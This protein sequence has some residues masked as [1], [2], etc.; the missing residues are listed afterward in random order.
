MRPSLPPLLAC[1]LGLWAAAAASY[2]LGEG[3]E[4][5]PCLLVAAF[6]GV[7]AAVAAA[8]LWRGRHVLACSAF[9]GVAL[10]LACGG[11]G[12]AA[13]HDAMAQAEEASA[14]V[15]R[16]EALEDG[17]ASAYGAQCR[18]R[19]TAA[20]GR[21][22]VVRVS[23]PEGVEPPRYGDAFEARSRLSRP[24]GTTASYC[25]Q[26]GTAAVARVDDVAPL[27]RDGLVGLLLGV[28]VRAVEALSAAGGDAAALLQALVCG[29]RGSLGDSALY[30]DFKATGL[31]HLVAVS[32]AH[33]VI[34]SGCVALAL[35]ALRA[36]HALAVVLQAAFL[37]AYLVFAAAPV[38]AVRAA[39]MALAGMSACFARRRPA[40]LNALS[41]CV[42]ALVAT[43]PHTAVSVSFALSA[44]STLGIVLLS[45]LFGS[46]MEALPVRLPRFLRDAFALTF[47]SGVVTVPASAALFAQL[48]L[49]SPW[50]NALA[51]PLFAL[52]CT[53]G[54]V[55][56][57]AAL[58][59]PAAASAAVGLAGAAAHVLAALVHA[60]AG[61]PFASVPVGAP[62]VPRIAASALAVFLLWRFWPRPRGRTLLV[63]AG[64]AAILL[65]AYV[66]AVPR[67]A[68]HEIVMLDVGQ[69]DA[70]LVRSEGSAVLVDTGNRDQALREGLAR[71]GVWR[72]DAV[73]VTHGD[74]DHCG[75]LASL[76]G[77]VGVGRVCVARDALSCPCASCRGLCADACAL[78]GGDALCGL[79]VGDVVRCGAFELAVVWPRAFSD[80]GG[81]AD[82]LCLLARADV[83]HDGFVDWT[84]LFCGDAEAEQLAELVGSHAVGTVDVYKV[85]HHGS[86]AALDDA[87][88][89]A[90]SPCIALVSVGENNRYGHPAPETLERLDRVGARVF[91]TDEQGDVSCE[92]TADAIDVVTLR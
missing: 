54:L 49:V 67:L 89:A 13:L 60:L 37:L 92:L 78:V 26:Q 74:D 70:F 48:S 7:L 66:V 72:L 19:A 3:M 15:W 63:A 76:R 12:A 35:R 57:L 17:Q 73:M 1:A 61:V 40:P 83:D 20:D 85:G 87:V 25:W 45:G 4:K 62:V 21:S 22:F 23:F 27:E 39:C 38:S 86:R 5:G 81:N 82:S 41:L 59:V 53:G 51:S 43:S 84:A 16:F 71:H 91:R 75:S 34:V 33:L 30:A 55:A 9:L 14:L 68:G 36:P 24:E 52:V 56:A 90:L 58:A 77:V 88:A 8:A 28:R 44:G 31:A 50:A 10:G 11:A 47:A 29:W 79:E 64:A 80:E 2:A 65:G 69:G 32:G 46:W 42:M 18:A 6:G